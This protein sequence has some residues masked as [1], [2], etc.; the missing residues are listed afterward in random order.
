M[1]R[2]QVLVAA[3][4]VMN[5]AAFTTAEQNPVARISWYANLESGFAVAKQTNRPILLVS[6]APSCL[7][8]PGV[9]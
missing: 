9:W 3:C 4:L 5:V 1:M 2:F 8:V 6:G 7:G